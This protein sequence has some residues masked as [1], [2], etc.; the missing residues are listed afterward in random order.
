MTRAQLLRSLGWARLIGR[1]EPDHERAVYWRGYEAG[2]WGVPDCTD[3]ASTPA[4]RKGFR[5]GV[6]DREWR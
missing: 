1:L 3:E 5:H 4:Y 6:I 2:L